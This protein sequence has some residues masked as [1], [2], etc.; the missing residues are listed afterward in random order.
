MDEHIEIR[1]RKKNGQRLRVKRQV[2]GGIELVEPDPLQRTVG[3]GFT[4]RNEATRIR[5]DTIRRLRGWLPGHF[6]LRMSVEDGSLILRGVDAHA[7]P[8]GFYRLRAQIEEVASAGPWVPVTL[9]HDG[10]AVATI[11]LT[12]DDRA[13]DVDLARCDEAIHDV[14]TRSSIDGADA[15]SWLEDDSRR[16]TRQACMLNLLA[17]LRVRPR[18]SRPLLALVDHV[19]WAANDRI[20]ARVDRACLDTLTTLALNA[21]QPFYDEG[22]PRSDVHERLLVA[23]PEKPEVKARFTGLR[24][25]RGEGKPSMQAVVAVPPPDLPYTYAEFDLDLGNPLQD[26]AGFF[27]HMGEL[28]D[29]K[30]TN[31]LDLRKALAKTN[32]GKY[33]YYT[34]TAA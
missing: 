24:S 1:F 22:T 32:A 25:F 29:G 27:V 2:P 34:V 30:S 8:E 14:L 9:P 15:V 26:L 5:M 28:L 31:H 19:F 20:Y 12:L 18:A 6:E 3:L 23:I 4:A 17:S 16:P 13:I 11:D 7:L 33:L 21:D 10:H